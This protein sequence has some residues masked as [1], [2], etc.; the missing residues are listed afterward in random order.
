[1]DTQFT[2][3]SNF[4]TQP[5]L[6]NQGDG[7]QKIMRVLRWV[8]VLGMLIAGYLFLVRDVADGDVLFGSYAF[9]G[10]S[11][12]LTLGGWICAKYLNDSAGGR[13]LFGLSAI[14]MPVHI[15]QQ[16]AFVLA[17]TRGNIDPRWD[18]GMQPMITLMVVT[19]PIIVASTWIGYTGWLRKQS[20]VF[21]PLY[22]LC[23]LALLLPT[24]S[25]ESVVIIATLMALPC[26]IVGSIFR[27]QT[28][29]MHTAEGIFARI[30]LFVPFAL[31]IG[32]SV[33]A[34]QGSLLLLAYCLAFIGVTL[35]YPVVRQL[36]SKGLRNLIRLLALGMQ[37]TAWLVLCAW[38]QPFEWVPDQ[39]GPMLVYGIPFLVAMIQLHVVKAEEGLLPRLICSVAMLFAYSVHVAFESSAEL[40]IFGFILGVAY[41]FF[42]TRYREKWMI[43][44]GIFL[45]VVAFIK[46]IFGVVDHIDTIGWSGIG[47]IGFFL[48]VAVSII[49]KK[50]SAIASVIHTRK[51]ALKD[52]S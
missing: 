45:L 15:A 43:V 18:I 20:R 7:F 16:A 12:A 21:A 48:V 37:S 3:E 35:Y 9:F 1:M 2:N 22:I 8:G 40:S 41:L 13:T 4:E 42:S 38:A 28:I 5:E 32:R 33:Y 19:L 30:T 39:W 25:P 46:S 10:F 34:G 23:N 47:F 17:A 14:L 49:E 36:K 11:V 24:R 44:I 52:W 50:R 27:Q 29:L 51:N 31:I 26:F 6:S